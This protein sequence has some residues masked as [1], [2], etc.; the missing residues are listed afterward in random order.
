MLEDDEFKLFLKTLGIRIRQ[1]RK[2]KHLLMRDIM[3][4]TGYYDAQ[5]RKYESG[6]SLNVASL[7][8][9]ALALKVSL[10]ELLDGLGQWPILSVAEITAQS[11]IQPDSENE[12]DREPNSPPSSTGK[13]SKKNV[14]AKEGGVTA[15]VRSARTNRV[16]EIRHMRKAGSRG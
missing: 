14:A 11:G 1:I 8:K 2:E 7:L 15:T 6:G 10:N 16:P 5:W 9:I 13:G 4:A 3:I 12:P